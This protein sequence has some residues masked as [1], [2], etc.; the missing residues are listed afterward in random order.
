VRIWPT[1]LETSR[2][3]IAPAEVVRATERAWK[4]YRAEHGLD[5]YGKPVEEEPPG[6]RETPGAQVH[7]TRVLAGR[8]PPPLR[9][10]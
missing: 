9:Q 3:G 2:N 10:A 6:I 1:T 5:L 7:I 8:L 4:R